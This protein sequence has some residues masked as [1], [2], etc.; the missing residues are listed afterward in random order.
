MDIF[1]ERLKDLRIESGYKQDEIAKKLNVTK[2][3]YGYYE[4]G[5]NEP[6]LETLKKIAQTFQVSTD[7][8]LGLIQIPNYPVSFR[9]TEDLSLSKQELEAVKKMKELHLLEEISMD[10]DANV[11]RLVR[12]WEFIKSEHNA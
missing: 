5:R 11:S 10:P 3:A 12:Y 8:L 6:S 4:Q 7:Y 9:V 2:S 1:S